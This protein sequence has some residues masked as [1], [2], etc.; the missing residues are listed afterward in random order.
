[1]EEKSFNLQGRTSLNAVVPRLVAMAAEYSLPE[2]K[3]RKTH[4]SVEPDNLEEI[5]GS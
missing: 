5:P 1:M 2:R 3:K 4:A